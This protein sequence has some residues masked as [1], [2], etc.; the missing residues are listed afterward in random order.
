M[1]EVIFTVREDEAGVRLDAY[2]RHKLCGPSRVRV[3]RMI[4]EQLR[5]L[6]SQRLK[7]SSIVRSG[8]RFAVAQE[9]SVEDPLPTIP[10]VYEDDAILVLDKPAN[11]A[12]HPAGRHHLHTLTAALA[13][14][15]GQRAHPA[16][17]LDRET[18]GLVA[19]G[20]GRASSLLKRA[21]AR[22]E[23]QKNYLAIV[24]G[25]PTSDAFAID[26]PLELGTGRVRVRMTVGVGKP[27][28]TEIQVLGRYQNA[29]GER[30]SL[31]SCSPRTG[32]QHQI[33]AHLGSAGFPLVGDKI[34]GPDETIFIRCT[35]GGMTDR[36]R[37]RLRLS[38]HALHAAEL[39]FPHP[40]RGKLV[41]FH[42][43][44]PPDLTAFLAELRAD[45]SSPSRGLAAPT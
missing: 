13:A 9:T 21:F 12:V 3:Q 43:P 11:L 34:Y 24:D 30:F 17:R 5:P 10:V 33:R 27:S 4:R 41:R 1:H 25:W 40:L 26:L 29:D 38:R 6:G 14:R 39:A 7:P 15:P 2:L 32:R 42:S 16:H 23:V 8:L 35:E 36:D 44:L 20:I 45:C 18:S 31:L 19:C 37:Q 28:L 22:G